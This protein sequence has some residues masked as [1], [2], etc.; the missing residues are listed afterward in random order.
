MHRWSVTTYDTIPIRFPDDYSIWQAEMPEVALQYPFL[1]NALFAIT[2]FELSGPPESAAEDHVKAGFQLKERAVQETP[3]LPETTS[4]ETN[5][6]LLYQGQLLLLLALASVQYQPAGTPLRS[7]LHQLTTDLTLLQKLQD[8]LKIHSASLSGHPLHQASIP[9][10]ELPSQTLDLPTAAIFRRLDELNK[11]RPGPPPSAPFEVR[12]QATLHQ[13]SCKKAIFWLEEAY[14]NLPLALHH[15]EYPG[16]F[17]DHALGW[18]SLIDSE[19][20]GALREA[21]EIA[22]LLF[23]VWALL[24]QTRGNRFWWARRLGTRMLTAIFPIMGSSTSTALREIFEWANLQ[25]FSV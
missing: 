18:I 11:S 13:S 19:Y 6:A 22:S 23:L 12:F 7:I 3:P 25:V 9:A 20:I 24:I 14:T 10:S 4:T 15:P 17:Y 21:D 16:H 2:T 1:L 5:T 8:H